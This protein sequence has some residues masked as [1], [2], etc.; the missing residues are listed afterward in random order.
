MMKKRTD[1][2]RLKPLGIKP[3]HALRQEREVAARKPLSAETKANIVR[4]HVAHAT[5]R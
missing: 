3:L 1:A 4:L 2:E 5:P